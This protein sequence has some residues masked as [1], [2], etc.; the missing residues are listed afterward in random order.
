MATVRMRYQDAAED[1]DM[2]LRTVSE[3]V[4]SLFHDSQPV[5]L[6]STQGSILGAPAR[7]AQKTV[8]VGMKHGVPTGEGK[9]AVLRVI[10]QPLLPDMSMGGRYRW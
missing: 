4:L 9:P 8:G 7:G 2:R 3:N 5:E 1:G 6:G 10:P